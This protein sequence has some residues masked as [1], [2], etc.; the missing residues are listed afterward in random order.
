MHVTPG[1]R[2]SVPELARMATLSRSVFARRFVETVGEP[3]L[4]YLTGLRLDK[5]AEL[6]QRTD[7]SLADI[8]EA[9]GYSEPAFSRAFKARFGASPSFWRRR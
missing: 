4:R 9:V 8:S 5:A 7:R 3:P 2:W 1:R 6:L